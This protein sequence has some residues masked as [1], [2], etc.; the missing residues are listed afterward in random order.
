MA[1]PGL[2]PG[3]GAQVGAGRKKGTP[4]KSTLELKDA[5]AAA[6]GTDFDPVVTMAK[7]GKFGQAERYRFEPETGGFE[8][9]GAFPVSEKIQAKCLLEVAEYIHPKRRAIEHSDNPDNP[10]LRKLEVVFVPADQE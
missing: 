6:C 8:F 4:N 9:I 1:K 5:I 3:Q 10:L 2:K 7:I